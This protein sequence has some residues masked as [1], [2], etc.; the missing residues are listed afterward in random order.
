MNLKRIILAFLGAGALICACQKEEDLGTP[1]ITVDPSE[2]NLSQGDESQSVDLIA[3]RDWYISSKPDWAAL[4]VEDGK[5]STKSQTVTV[6]V[7][8]NQGNDRTGEIVFNIGLA[9]AALVI[10]QKGAKGPVR[11]G[12]GTMDDPYSVA[13]AVAY[14]KSL[15]SDVNSPTAVFVTGKVSSIEEAFSTNYGNGT[16]DISDDG[17]LESDQF[18]CYRVK[19][20]GNRSW[21]A[22]DPQI[23]AGDEVTIYGNIVN[24][25]GN[26]PETAQGTAF[27]Y[28]HNGKSEGGVVDP[29]NIQSSTVADF[30]SKADGNYY[31]LTGKVSDFK[32]GTNSSGKN[33]MQFNLTDD[34][35]KIVVYGFKDGQYDLWASKIKNGGTVVLTGTYELYTNKNTGA[36]QHEVMNTTIESFTEGSGGGG[37]Q[38][39]DIASS[40]IA[41][42]ISKADGNTYYRLTGK[43][44]DFSKGTTS[45]GKNWMQ[46]NLADDTGKILV[47]G[48]K[49]GQYD[50]WV[51][52]IKNGGTAVVTGT[53][54]FYSSK[55]QHEV[56]NATI[57]SFTEG[58]TQPSNPSGNGT[59]ES[60]YNAAAAYQLAATLGADDK[61]DDVY[62]AGKISS[63]KYPFN[64]QYGTATFDISDDGS[65]SGSQFTCYG[66]L[67][68]GNTSWKD[69]QTQVKEGDNVVIYGKLCNYQGNTPE[70]SNKEAYIY[71]LNGQTEPEEVQGGGGGS[72]VQ[73]GNVT[74]SEGNGA[75]TQKAKVNGK[76]MSILKLGTGSATGT[77]TLTLPQASTKLSFYAI[78]WKDKPSELVFKVN[79]NQI[80]SLNPA[81]NAGLAG[82]PTYTI[83]VTDSDYYTIELGSSV[84]EVTVETA[85][86]NPR[87]ALFCITAE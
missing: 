59:L 5:A 34:T 56:M 18:T 81:A 12:S 75:Y 52:K 47:Y 53:Y 48:F 8:A 16:F 73:D 11:M 85:G 27:V 23:A 58:S 7:S 77:S 41:D 36:T 30:I 9:K 3:T 4:S 84:T 17:T 62:I 45:A 6:S 22:S 86:S 32:T 1:R 61:S 2:L 49:D 83:T 74:W 65:T 87:A 63:I 40:T 25:K 66:V 60:P 39:G 38:Q 19:Y 46:F 67:Y 51:S 13:G 20:L 26:K 55:N 33:Y 42:F 82:N 76:E 31:R 68:L 54:E 29:T 28:A 79:G 21:K 37:G 24:F 10:N 57:E 78:S 44:S 80:K 70:S 14:V 64:T 15:G 72:D 69:G 35:G 50:Q 43:V 71:S